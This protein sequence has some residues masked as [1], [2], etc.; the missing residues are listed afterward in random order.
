MPDPPKNVSF[1]TLDFFNFEIPSDK[2]NL[3]YDYTFLCALPPKMREAWGNRYAEIIAPGGEFEQTV[4]IWS[5][6]LTAS[7]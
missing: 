2:F 5:N 3:A 1:K 6:W 7:V 4:T